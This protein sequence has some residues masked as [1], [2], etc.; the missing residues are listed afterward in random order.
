MID[1]NQGPAWWFAWLG[2]TDTNTGMLR[3]LAAIAVYI[4]ICG[5]IAWTIS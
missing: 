5:T 1:G 3:F 2:H 4:L